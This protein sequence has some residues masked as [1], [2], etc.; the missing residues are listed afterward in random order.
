[1][2]LTE[3]KLEH[4]PVLRKVVENYLNLSP[5]G[6]A[7]D[8]TVGL[9]GHTADMVV[10]VGDSGLVIGFE[11]DEEHYIYAKKRFE[12]SRGKVVLI[13]RNF[14]FL[15]EELERRGSKEVD[16]ILFDLGIASPH[17]DRPERGFSFSKEGHLDMRFDTSQGRTAADIVNTCS[18]TEL[19]K[20]FRDYGEERFSAKI[21]KTIIAER[22]KRTIRTTTQ[23]SDLIVSLVP[24]ESRRKMSFH[25]ATRVFQALR[26]AVNHELEVLEEALKQAVDVLK[27]G[28]RLVAISYHSLED[29][30]VKNVL[31][32]ETKGCIC[33]PEILIC[34]CHHV[35]RIKVLT[36]K[37]ITP[38]SQEIRENPRSRSAKLRAAERI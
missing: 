7:I 25:P 20:I 34:Q 18:F 35:P 32:N 22:R 5:G 3:D 9:G 15:Q 8:A 17:V 29:R 16:G 37:P 33:P 10:K 38:D 30:I 4:V 13:N 1:M 27:K 12:S 26:I 24:R 2:E 36:K 11:Q 6:I 19:V 31:R 21:A 23:L 14:V 28:G